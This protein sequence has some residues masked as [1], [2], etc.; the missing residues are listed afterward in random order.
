MTTNWEKNPNYPTTMA[1][2]RT[3]GVWGPVKLGW[4]LHGYL[5]IDAKGCMSRFK[6]QHQRHTEIVQEV[7][8]ETSLTISDPLPTAS[9]KTQILICE[10]CNQPWE[11]ELKRGRVPATCPGCKEFL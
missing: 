3:C 11:R 4:D 8:E 7:A 1:T 9:V 2:C 6:E 5:C 10:V